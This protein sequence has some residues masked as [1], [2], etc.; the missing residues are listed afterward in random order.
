[1]NELRYA[2]CTT[3]GTRSQWSLEWNSYFGN[4]NTRISFYA[5]C[6][7]HTHTHT[8]HVNK[9]NKRWNSIF[10]CMTVRKKH[11]NTTIISPFM[12]RART[13]A[14]CAVHV[15]KQV[16]IVI[17]ELEKTKIVFLVCRTMYVT[18]T[19]LPLWGPIFLSKRWHFLHFFWI[20]C[21]NSFFYLI[22][23]LSASEF[24]AERTSSTLKIEY[25]M[26][27]AHNGGDGGGDNDRCGRPLAMIND[28]IKSMNEENE[29]PTTTT[30]AMMTTATTTIQKYEWTTWPF[31]WINRPMTMTTKPFC[32]MHWSAVKK[33]VRTPRTQPVSWYIKYEWEWVRARGRV[34]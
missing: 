7:K 16:V 8:L 22:V 2:L 11:F 3:Y 31:K 34:K 18:S 29:K 26:R 23:S 30:T 32:L 10:R 28:T 4:N 5:S 17:A 6:G 1:M 12:I 27:N 13:H 25:R 24:L 33:L 14:T 9:N 19:N 20:E 21:A 15:E